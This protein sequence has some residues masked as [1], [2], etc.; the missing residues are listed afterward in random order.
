MQQILRNARRL[1]NPRAIALRLIAIVIT[2]PKLRQQAKALAARFPAL[3]RRLK[4]RIFSFPAASEL[5]GAAHV[6]GRGKMQVR[7]FERDQIEHRRN[8][9]VGGVPPASA[10]HGVVAEA[11]EGARE[12]DSRRHQSRDMRIPDQV[13]GARPLRAV[14]RNGPCGGEASEDLDMSGRQEPVQHR[15]VSP[16]GQRHRRIL[17]RED[18][19]SGPGFEDGVREPATEP[20]D[21]PLTR[22]RLKCLQIED[23]AHGRGRNSLGK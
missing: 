12:M 14:S 21:A 4:A 11:L 6:Q 23:Q 3:E 9:K 2:R 18:R 10:N 8:G 15:P 13:R 7:V 20:P 1:L 5:M 17:K 19:A 16:C 22:V